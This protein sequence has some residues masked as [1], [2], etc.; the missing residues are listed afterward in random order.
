M[1]GVHVL[2]VDREVGDKLQD[3]TGKWVVQA[4]QKWRSKL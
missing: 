4:L 2:G 3:C 1:S